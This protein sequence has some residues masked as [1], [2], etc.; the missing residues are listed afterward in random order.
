MYI[1]VAMNNRS[2]RFLV[3]SLRIYR[4]FNSCFIKSFNLYIIFLS[5]L[6][7]QLKLRANTLTLNTMIYHGGAGA[8]LNDAGETVS[9]NW[10]PT[11]SWPALAIRG[12][13]LAAITV[14]F[15]HPANSTAYEMQWKGVGPDGI[16]YYSAVRGLGTSSAP[17]MVSF[18]SGSTN[19]LPDSV[20]KYDHFV[21]S[22]Q[23]QSRPY[24]QTNWS[25]WYTVSSTDTVLYV[26]LDTPLT[27]TCLYRTIVENA[28]ATSGATNI[29]TAIANIWSRF[30]GLNF[31]TWNNNTLYYYKPG[32]TSSTNAEHF[33]ALLVSGNGSGQC[34]AWSELFTQCLGVHGIDNC[35]IVEVVAYKNPY[36]L[37]I[38][39]LVNNWNTNNA[40]TSQSGYYK[41]RLTFLTNYLDMVPVPAGANYGDLTSLSET[42]GQGSG[43]NSP[44]QKIFLRHYIV[45]YGTNYYDPSY[46][47]TYNNAQNMEASSIYGFYSQETT[48]ESGFFQIDVRRKSFHGLMFNQ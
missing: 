44:S 27:D 1:C 5:L 9:P 7:S 14:C 26:C 20:K 21:I 43:T 11:N 48:N 36:L 18:D 45:K 31:K 33:A 30:S 13:P 39:F 19:S 15:T 6:F 37:D 47:L 35:P 42:Q 25:D 17:F 29:E 23:Y 2:F 8:V 12:L 40:G 28:C 16:I 3:P 24:G 46:G 4:L 10:T 34:G 32:T 22:W 38:G 41:W